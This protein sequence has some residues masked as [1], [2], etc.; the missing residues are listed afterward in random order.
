MS[1]EVIATPNAPAAI[2]PYSQAI[3]ANGFVYVSGQ[4]PLI[5]G[6]KDFAG[7]TVALQTE[8]ALKNIAAIL[9]AAGTDMAH[10]VKMTV[11]LADMSTFAEM[12]AVYNTFFPAEPP[13]RTTFA[14]KGLPMNILV[15]IDAVA[16]LP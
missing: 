6:T 14:A 13:A 12:N 9:A 11:L 8:Q 7:E 10:V 16:V 15:E 2:G 4:G 3:K 5:P 1:R